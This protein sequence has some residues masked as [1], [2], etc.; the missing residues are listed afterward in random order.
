MIRFVWGGGQFIIFFYVAKG[1]ER[2]QETVSFDA[3]KPQPTTMHTKL[4]KF[5]VTY[6]YFPPPAPRSSFFS[7]FLQ[8]SPN[9]CRPTLLPPPPNGGP[10]LMKYYRRDGF[11]RLIRF[12]LS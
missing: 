11:H 3:P 4:G 9:L 6:I 12:G 7:F 2:K 8:L 5:L 1:G 10:R